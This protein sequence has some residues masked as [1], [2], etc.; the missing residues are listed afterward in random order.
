[1]KRFYL[2]LRD[3]KGYGRARIAVLRKTFG[4]MRRMLLDGMEYKW[5]EQALSEGKLRDYLRIRGSQETTKA[6]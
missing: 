2:G 4:M 6:A 1:M 5:K 3:R